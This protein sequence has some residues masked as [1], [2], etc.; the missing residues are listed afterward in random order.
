[1]FKVFFKKFFGARYEMIF[2]SLMT[3]FLMYFAT[4]EVTYNMP[5]DV[6]LLSNCFL[7]IILTYQTIT[8]N[9]NAESF[10]RLF[11]YPINGTEFKIKYIISILIYSLFTR[12]II[13]FIIFCNVSEFAYKSLFLFILSTIAITML[14]LA[15]FLLLKKKN[16]FIYIFIVFELLFYIICTN[17]N[18]L[19]ASYLINILISIVIIIK[20]NVLDF[21]YVKKMNTKVINKKNTTF[22]TYIIRYFTFNKSYLLSIVSMIIIACSAVSFKPDLLNIKYIPY[23]FSIII[24]N[25][26]LAI[27]ISINKSL[28]KKIKS[29]P[30]QIKTFYVPYFLAIF[31]IDLL[32][33]TIFIYCSNFNIDLKIIIIQLIWCIENALITVFLEY[34]FPVKN[35]N[36]ETELWNNPR[37]YISMTILFL[38]AGVLYGLL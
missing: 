8:S 3:A 29:Y 21:M 35:W 17:I 16:I 28:Q 26:P 2:I 33:T 5:L 4:S 6:Y 34:K 25:T 10:K 1:M 37:K 15:V 23:I 22:F 18:I 7:T 12:N 32:I 36:T 20:A 9:D 19:I 27:V 30:N 24:Y 31:I 14:M 38:Q 11:S 13:L